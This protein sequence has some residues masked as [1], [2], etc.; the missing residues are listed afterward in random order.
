MPP[1]HAKVTQ[2]LNRL[3]QDVGDTVDASG[4]TWVPLVVIG[5][6]PCHAR[7]T[8]SVNGDDSVVTG[9]SRSGEQV[10]CTGTKKPS[11]AEINLA[12]SDLG[13]QFFRFTCGGC[14]R[15]IYSE[16]KPFKADGPGQWNQCA[17]SFSTEPADYTVTASSANHKG[18]DCWNAQPRMIYNDLW[19]SGCSCDTPNSTPEPTN[20]LY[21]L[22][23]TTS[24]KILEVTSI[25]SQVVGPPVEAAG[26]TWVPLVKIGAGNC[27]A[28]YTDSINGDMVNCAGTKKP[29]DSEINSA[30]SALGGETIFRFVCDQCELFVNSKGSPWAADVAGQWSWVSPSFSV[31]ESSYL[32]KVSHPN[33]RG[34]DAYANVDTR[35]IYNDNWASGC[36]C[37]PGSQANPK[38]G[39]LYALVR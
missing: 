8:G 30:I 38:T 22:L 31:E 32:N 13:A 39:W 27:H 14:E 11:D 18:I 6:G 25:L 19:G 5:D 12:I 16:S 10:A 3:S 36:T 1:P 26:Q 23:T 24:T 7:Y 9:E 2:A 15:F 20:R 28:S 29:S 4:Q 34:I 21:A 37:V 33:H 17:T 35:M